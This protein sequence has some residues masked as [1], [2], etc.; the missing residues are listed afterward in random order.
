MVTTSGPEEVIVF[1]TDKGAGIAPE[2]PQN[3]FGRNYRAMG[4][5]QEPRTD[6]YGLAATDSDST[7]RD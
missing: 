3:L 4:S 1:V 2:V 5:S 6:S 7:S